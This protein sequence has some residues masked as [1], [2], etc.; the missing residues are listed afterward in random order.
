MGA[1]RVLPSDS[2]L[3]RWAKTMTHQQ[4]ADRVYK[5]EGVRVSR[6]SVSA[7]LSRAGLT[8]R[9]RYADTIPWSPIKIA[10]NHHY[11]LTMLRAKARRD[12]GLPVPAE[13]V[14]RLDSWLARLKADDAVVAYIYDSPDGFY[15]VYREKAD[16]KGIVRKP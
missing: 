12:S 6:S 2:I 3:K 10:H 4:I 14:E 7:A 8:N 16:G 15:Y 13:Q 11:A 5:E 9:V 1:P